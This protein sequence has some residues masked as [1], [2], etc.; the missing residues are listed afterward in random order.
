MEPIVSP[1]NP[2]VADDGQLMAPSLGELFFLPGDWFIYLLTTR[3]PALAELLGIGGSGYGGTAAGAF[4][5]IFWIALA[6]SLIALTS[7]VRRFD[8][9]LTGGLL[10]LVA[11]IK[12]RV[13]MAAVFARYRRQQRSAPRKEPTF[14][15]EEPTVSR[16][17]VRTLDLYAKLSP[18]YALSV[19]DVAEELDLRVHESRSLLERLQK[20]KLLQS[21]VGGLDGET[22]YTLT[23]GGRALVQMRH[24]RPRH[25]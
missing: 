9:A 22:A 1:P 18:G 8:R 20:L 2:F 17:E 6:L 11:E 15:G 16:N 23:A 4:A 14:E 24:T 3:A 10:D 21:T 19:R 25:A 12:R 5:W 13:R 7:A